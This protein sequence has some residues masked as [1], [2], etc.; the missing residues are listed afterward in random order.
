MVGRRQ[1]GSGIYGRHPNSV[2]AVFVS[3]KTLA[4]RFEISLDTLDQ[5]VQDGF[6]PPPTIVRGQIR[7]WHWATIESLLV[8]EQHPEANRTSI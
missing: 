1:D 4:G 5:W 3:R 2:D 7:R 6:L 8:G